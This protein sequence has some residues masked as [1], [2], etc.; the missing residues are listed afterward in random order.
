[1]EKW[2]RH[3]EK[4]KFDI[5]SCFLGLLWRNLVCNFMWKWSLNLFIGTKKGKQ[6]AFLRWQF[7]T[8]MRKVRDQFLCEWGRRGWILSWPKSEN[9]NIYKYKS[10]LKNCIHLLF[11]VD[12]KNKGKVWFVENKNFVLEIWYEISTFI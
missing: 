3:E 8:N 7:T 5:S 2:G 9:A 11:W 10:R 12:A 4:V 1:M 6:F